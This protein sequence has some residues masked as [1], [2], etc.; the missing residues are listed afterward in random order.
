MVQVIT[1]I[2]AALGVGLFCW[3]IFSAVKSFNNS[4][5]RKASERR[6]ISKLNRRELR[7]L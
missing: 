6:P 1:L 7:R 4:D 3:I 2:I 5:I